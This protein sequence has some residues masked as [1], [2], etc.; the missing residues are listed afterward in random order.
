MSPRESSAAS[1][2][3]ANHRTISLPCQ[4]LTEW[5]S[6]QL[7]DTLSFRTLQTVPNRRI[8]FCIISRWQTLSQDQA[9]RSEG[10]TFLSLWWSSLK[11]WHKLRG[12]RALV[13]FFN[14]SPYCA[15]TAVISV[16]SCRMLKHSVLSCLSAIISFETLTPLGVCHVH[17]LCLSVS[18]TSPL[19][20]NTVKW[21]CFSALSI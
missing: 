11:L 4:L 12:Q 1:T 14:C 18:H 17:I 8:W 9:V 13:V 21:S 20:A 10:R 15:S 19:S 2:R 3:N 7:K 16:K 5:K 6:M